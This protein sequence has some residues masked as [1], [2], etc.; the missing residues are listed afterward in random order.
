LTCLGSEDGIMTGTCAGGLNEPASCRAQERGLRPL[1]CSRRCQEIVPRARQR[2]AGYPAT[3]S[4]G[5]AAGRLVA[6][7]G[8]PPTTTRPTAAC[9]GG[10]GQLAEGRKRVEGRREGKISFRQGQCPR[11]LLCP[12]RLIA[13][14]CVMEG[15]GPGSSAHDCEAAGTE[16]RPPG[17]QH[18]MPA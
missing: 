2:A 7:S 15:E 8:E 16:C 11:G 4:T 14:P 6:V 9:T 18:P 1:H 17:P 12:D 13:V 3:A 5:A 10:A